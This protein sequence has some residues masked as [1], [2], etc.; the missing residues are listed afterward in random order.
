[1]KLLKYVYQPNHI[2]I[3]ISI[4][5]LI[6]VVIVLPNLHQSQVMKQEQSQSKILINS[7]I[8]IHE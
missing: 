5:V 3:I 4:E 7:D 2:C 1:M 6:E 8:I